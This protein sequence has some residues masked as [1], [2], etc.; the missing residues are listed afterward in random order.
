M[1]TWLEEI[2][3]SVFGR[4]SA[5]D[6]L[7][8]LRHLVSARVDL[9]RTHYLVDD[10]ERRTQ[11]DR[12]YVLR[13]DVDSRRDDHSIAVFS[14]G[15][16]VGYLSDQASREIAPLLDQLGGAAV[17]NGAGAARGS[18]RLRLDLPTRSALRVFAAA[19]QA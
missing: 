11:G 8:D 4:S 12:L 10:R 6:A 13:R 15:R 2:L 7:P 18:I 9:E 19:R 17:V 1:P 3:H 14:N 16:G 5:H